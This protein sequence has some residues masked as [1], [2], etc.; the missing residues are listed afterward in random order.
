MERHSAGSAVRTLARKEERRKTK[1]QMH[2]GCGKKNMGAGTPTNTKVIHIIQGFETTAV[3]EID[4]TMIGVAEGLLMTG[5][6]GMTMIVT[7][8]TNVGVGD[9]ANDLMT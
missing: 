4:T 5:I 8:D 2:N 6:R 9:E 3:S 1:E 7:A